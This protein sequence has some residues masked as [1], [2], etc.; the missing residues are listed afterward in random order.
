[1]IPLHS[2][3][4]MI[5]VDNASLEASQDQWRC[6]GFENFTLMQIATGFPCQVPSTSFR[7]TLPAILHESMYPSSYHE[8]TR[9]SSTRQPPCHAPHLNSCPSSVKPWIIQVFYGYCAYLQTCTYMY[10]CIYNTCIFPYI[11]STV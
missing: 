11:Q 9:M 3:R 5:E 8:E 1:M 10:Y 6:I 4:N 7:M 2:Q